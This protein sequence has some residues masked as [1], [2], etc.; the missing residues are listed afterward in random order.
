MATNVPV[1]LDT[2]IVVKIQLNGANRRFKVPL[3]DLG[4]NVFPEK[5][6]RDAAAVAGSGHRQPG[7][8]TRRAYG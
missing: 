6:R 5:V 2:L 1:T 4:A 8:A 7:R 3:R